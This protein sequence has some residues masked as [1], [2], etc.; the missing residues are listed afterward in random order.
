MNPLPVVNLTQVMLYSEMWWMATWRIYTL[1]LAVYGSM[2]L[3]EFAAQVEALR[4]A[5]SCVG[6]NQRF[7]LWRD[8]LRI[9]HRRF[10]FTFL[11]SPQSSLVQRS[12]S[13]LSFQV[14]G[15]RH[16]ILK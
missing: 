1:L 6:S 12:V 5:N 9:A 2:I 13:T 7:H 4:A 16:R 10:S 3:D 8:S 14:E 11:V 15:C